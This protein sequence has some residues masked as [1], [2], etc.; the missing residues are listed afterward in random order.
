MLTPLGKCLLTV[1]CVLVVALRTLVHLYVLGRRSGRHPRGQ[2]RHWRTLMA[3]GVQRP[4]RGEVPRRFHVPASPE[5]RSPN[6]PVPATPSPH[7]GFSFSDAPCRGH[8]AHRRIAYST[9]RATIRDGRMTTDRLPGPLT[10]RCL[11]SGKGGRGGLRSGRT[12]A[13]N[14]ATSCAGTGLASGRQGRRLGHRGRGQRRRRILATK[15]SALTAASWTG[16]NAQ[17]SSMVSIRR[18]DAPGCLRRG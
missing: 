11:V 13:S 1:H 14:A 12:H 8:A 6:S 2:R 3:A 5:R 9:L 7:A 18:S 4:R 17:L 10:R 15:A 16:V